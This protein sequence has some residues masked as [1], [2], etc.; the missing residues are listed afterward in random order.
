MAAFELGLTVS[1]TATRPAALPS[2]ATYIGVLPSL[3]RRS[4]SDNRRS[5]A[6][7]RSRMSLAFPNS[8]LLAVDPTTDAKP[9]DCREALSINQRKFSAHRRR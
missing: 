1:A 8:T 3:A 9:G 5:I 2:I 7:A 6:T 4:H